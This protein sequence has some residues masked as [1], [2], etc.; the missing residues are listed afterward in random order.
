MFYRI[1]FDGVI[2]HILNI[3]GY[4]TNEQKFRVW[5]AGLSASLIK[6]GKQLGIKA[7]TAAFMGLSKYVQNTSG[8]SN[9]EK[10][11]LIK[12]AQMVASEKTVDLGVDNK[13]EEI[14]NNL[15]NK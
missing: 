13:L 7:E 15:K 10:I 14:L 5:P 6:Q 2:G 11:S 8:L 9:K 12:S 3:A 1:K 4:T